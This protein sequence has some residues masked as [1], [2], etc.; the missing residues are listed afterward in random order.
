MRSDRWR[1]VAP[2]VLLKRFV[3]QNHKVFAPLTSRAESLMQDVPTA[4]RGPK[5]WKPWLPGLPLAATM[6]FSRGNI[7]KNG[8]M[9]IARAGLGYETQEAEGI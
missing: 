2:L 9:K 5:Y 3:S 6:I 7:L 8:V 1:L 4:S